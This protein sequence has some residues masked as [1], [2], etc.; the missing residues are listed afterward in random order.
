MPFGFLAKLSPFALC[1][2]DSR[3]PQIPCRAL[4]F[5]PPRPA[6]GL[7]SPELGGVGGCGPSSGVDGPTGLASRGPGLCYPEKT[8]PV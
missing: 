8:S 5:P 2:P 3:D 7:S 1:L 4:L 6:L